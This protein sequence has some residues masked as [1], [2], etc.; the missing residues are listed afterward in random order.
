RRYMIDRGSDIFRQINNAV[1]DL[2]NAKGV[3]DESIQKLKVLKRLKVL[4]LA[5]N[6]ISPEAAKELLGQLPSCQIIGVRKRG[7]L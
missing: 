5:G 4:T 2:Q 1:L 7:R 6:G 3:D